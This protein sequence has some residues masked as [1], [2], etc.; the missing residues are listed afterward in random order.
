MR[1]QPSPGTT[2]SSIAAS[3]GSRRGL[4]VPAIRWATAL[5]VILPVAACAAGYSPLTSRDRQI[6]T[7]IDSVLSADGDLSRGREWTDFEQRTFGGR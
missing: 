5:L 3:S 7:D 1:D 2:T 6:T 4:D